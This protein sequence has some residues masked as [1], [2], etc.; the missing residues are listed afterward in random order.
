MVLE[1]R[2]I[3][4]DQQNKQPRKKHTPVQSIE[5]RLYNGG[6][7]ASSINNGGKTGQLC[8]ID[9]VQ[10]ITFTHHTKINK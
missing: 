1:Q 2:Q 7:T 3:Y 10:W 5:T 9:Y 4:I 6:K 8:A